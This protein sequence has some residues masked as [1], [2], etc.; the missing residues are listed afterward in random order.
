M[1]T[2]TNDSG[3]I[4]VTDTSVSPPIIERWLKDMLRVEQYVDII[5]FTG[6]LE[7]A[8]G[9]KEYQLA[10]EAT[11][12]A[13]RQTLYEYLEDYGG[14]GGGGVQ[15][16]T[17]LDTDNTDPANPV[18]QIAV[19][20]VTITGDGTVG[21]PLV[22]V[23]GG[24]ALEI[25]EDGIS[26]DA[27]VDEIN[28]K[29]PL[30]AT[31][32]AAGKVDVSLQGTAL[33]GAMYE[34]GRVAALLNITRMAYVISE[35]KIYVPSF[36]SGNVR[37]YANS[38]MELL[39]TIT[40]ITLATGCSF[41]PFL[42][43]VWTAGSSG[44][45]TRI[46]V[47][48]NAVISTIATS[49]TNINKFIEYTPTSGNRKAYGVSQSSIA[50][51]TGST[52]IIIDLVTF[53]VTNIA[54]TTA[55]TGIDA[56]LNM[57][58]SSDMF[59]HLVVTTIGTG[60]G[61]YILDCETDTLVASA[62][63][64]SALFTSIRGITYVPSIDRYYVCD[65]DGNAVFKLEPTSVS[66]MA[67]DSKN[68]AFFQPSIVEYDSINQ[69]LLI[70]EMGDGGK[71]VLSKVDALTGFVVSELTTSVERAGTLSTFYPV[72]LN[73][74]IVLCSARGTAASQ[75]VKVKYA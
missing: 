11:A 6:T 35:D 72:I 54:L 41:I 21:N 10:D 23:G 74:N 26:V 73:N 58:S 34:T 12:I 28:F 30:K 70:L 8:P 27:N 25:L 61:L 52:I 17:G 24:S 1:I 69:V 57:N 63:N 42:N 56:V 14:G 29:S 68:N 18:I 2:F 48:T 19:D 60:A 4:E 49:T 16:V 9:R 75:I 13:E 3:V 32:T 20:G 5:R 59:R 15:S 51:P 33:T 40:G 37:I 38:N 50:N 36:T 45:I 62:Y 39:A 65:Y 22:S 44:D 71:L 31:Q 43:E 66:T 46:N 7:D 53:G 67:L 55:H 64:P 47:S